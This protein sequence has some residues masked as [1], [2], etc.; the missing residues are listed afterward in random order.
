MTEICDIECTK[1]FFLYV[2]VHYK[3]KQRVRFVI[4][5]SYNQLPQLLFHLKTLKYQVGFNNESYDY[6]LIDLLLRNE[7][8]LLQSSTNSI[9]NTLFQQSQQAINSKFPLINKSDQLITQIDLYKI[10]H[11]DNSAKRTS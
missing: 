11:F 8:R 6:S 9:L 1:N 2:G 5:E 4:H 3:T 10:A 7:N